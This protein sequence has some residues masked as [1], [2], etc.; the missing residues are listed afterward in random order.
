MLLYPFLSKPRALLCPRL[1]FANSHCH[2][3]VEAPHQRVAYQSWH[4][5]HDRF[6]ISLALFQEVEKLLGSRS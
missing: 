4:C 1:I 6:D 5:S 2:S 3:S